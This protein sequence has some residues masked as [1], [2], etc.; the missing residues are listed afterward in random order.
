MSTGSGSESG[1]DPKGQQ[2]TAQAAAVGTVEGGGGGRGV[3]ASGG[4]RLPLPG[5]LA[6]VMDPK[7]LLWLGG[8]PHWPPS[9]SSSGRSR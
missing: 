2:S 3:A 8:W 6:A 5:D 4:L 1:N 9:R 7:R